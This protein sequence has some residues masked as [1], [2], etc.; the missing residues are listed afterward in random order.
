MSEERRR[1]D[2]LWIGESEGVCRRPDPR[3]ESAKP[4]PTAALVRWWRS[5]VA[6]NRDDTLRQREA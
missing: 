5:D 3:S 1:A 6:V 4:E 2:T